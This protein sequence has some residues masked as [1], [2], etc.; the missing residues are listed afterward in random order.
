[1][2]ADG[3]NQQ[4]VTLSLPSSIFS[5]S[6]RL[7]LSGQD[8]GHHAENKNCVTAKRANFQMLLIGVI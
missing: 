1:M 3:N 6:E 5:V 4:R 2:R 8:Q 7:A